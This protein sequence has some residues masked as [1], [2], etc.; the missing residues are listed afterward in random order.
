[1][2]GDIDDHHCHTR[3]AECVGQ[4]DPEAAG[5]ARDAGVGNLDGDLWV[6]VADGR[7]G[8]GGDVDAAAEFI[9]DG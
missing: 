6:D 1:V 8:G 9:L 4:R 5:F 2:R 3:A 7:A